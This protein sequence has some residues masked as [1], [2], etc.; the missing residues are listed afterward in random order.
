MFLFLDPCTV[1]HAVTGGHPL[2]QAGRHP[3][4][5][6]RSLQ[7]GYYYCLFSKHNSFLLEN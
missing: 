7:A 5:E 4:Q 6:L 1:S 2:L 3:R